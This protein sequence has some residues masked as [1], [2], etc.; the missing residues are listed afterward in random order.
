M[1]FSRKNYDPSSYGE[2][3][4]DI[5]ETELA[6]DTS[7]KTFIDG[8]FET[9][10]KRPRPSSPVGEAGLPLPMKKK[11]RENTRSESARQPQKSFPAKPIYSAVIALCLTLS[12][13]I[14]FSALYFSPSGEAASGEKE[15]PINRDAQEQT[16]AH[17]DSEAD[18]KSV[19]G[20]ESDTL[21]PSEL[22]VPATAELGA[23]FD[24]ASTG[25]GVAIKGFERADS[26]AASKLRAGDIVVAVGDQPVDSADAVKSALRKY[27]AGDT[28]EVYVTRNGQL[29]SFHV[30]LSD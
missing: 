26:D 21:A 18:N 11:R 29:L 3:L 16:D 4:A 19:V 28:A 8:L 23:F 2:E 17:A 14:L 22:P 1:R 6:K 25:K 27:S 5:N 15:P 9:E 20:A 30:R 7:D 13:Y 24:S 12:L 10:D